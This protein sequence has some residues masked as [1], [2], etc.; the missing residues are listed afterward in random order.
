MRALLVFSLLLAGSTAAKA[1]KL[2]IFGGENH[3]DYLGCLNC[4]EFSP[5]SIWNQ[6]G[7]YGNPFGH[8]LFNPFSPYR[9]PFSQYSM[10]K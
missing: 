9:N 1:E 5:D 8:N 6:F 7:R 2:M 4:N 3:R 10:C